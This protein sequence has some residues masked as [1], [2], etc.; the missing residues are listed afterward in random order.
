MADDAGALLVRSGLVTPTALDDARARVENLGGTLGEHL[1][2]AG[3]VSDEVLTDFYRSRLLVPQVNPNTLARLAVRVIA[4]IPSDMA[5]ELRAVPVALDAENNLTVA[6]SDPSDRHAVDEIAFFT[7]SY[8]VRAVATQ[9]QIAWCLAHYYGHVTALGQRL[10]QGGTSE[11]A[12]QPTPAPAAVQAPAPAPR[13]KGL[14]GKVEAMR[15]RGIAPITGPVNLVRPQSG[16]IAAAVPIPDPDPVIEPPVAVVI[17][18]IVEQP[19]RAGGQPDVSSDGV[20]AKPRARSVSGEIRIPGRRAESIKPAVEDPLEDESGPVITVEVSMPNEEE[21]TGPRKVAP[22]RRKVKSDPPELYARAGEVD[23]AGDRERSVDSGPGIIVADDLLEPPPQEDRTGEFEA[24]PRRDAASNGAPTQTIEVSDE[25]SAGVIIHERYDRESEPVLLERRR[26]SDPPTTITQ[27]APS[28][29]DDPDDDDVVV[30][31]AKKPFTR[32]ARPARPTQ[33][34]IGAL[35]AVTRAHR[36]TEAGTPDLD[37]PTGV[38]TPVVAPGPDDPSSDEIAAPPA[39]VRDDTSLHNL[40]EPPKPAP[41]R[42]STSP[43]ARKH[44]PTVDDLDDEDDELGPATSVMSAIELDD[45]IPQRNVDIVPAHLATR[46]HAA[47]PIEHDQVDDGWGPPGTTI[48][49]PLLGAIPGSAGDDVPG[50]IPVSSVDATPLI[51]APPSPPE[52]ARGAPKASP[53]PPPSDA[54][55][56]ATSRLL[57]LIRMLEHASDRDGVVGMM[58]AHL[59]ETHR[60]AGFFVVKAGAT[61]GV[62]E[63]SVFSIVPKPQTLPFATL[64]LDRPS[65]LQDVVGTRLPYR[66]PTHDEASRI[67]LAGVLGVAPVEILLMPV[68]VRE[69]VV[70]VLFAEH[71]LQHTFDDQLALAARA[72]GIALERILMAKRG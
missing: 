12:P 10:L 23:I 28:A 63:L 49:P 15:H 64:R 3:A 31:D 8:V 9:M 45:A 59:S 41:P 37:D 72:A 62:T 54:Q 25:A 14:T 26:P 65:T 56:D 50:R 69:R 52:P 60:R 5:I 57:D 16:Q 11:P 58:V 61:K 1:V 68:T 4:T 71:R 27:R 35:P 18:P 67:F 42:A 53:P 19:V 7:G 55:Q 40:A 39:P 47:A 33:V 46:R 30:L 70:G 32:A 48:P 38:D 24:A 66:G 13:K 36:D 29:A 17:A 20:P 2:F 51:V 34:G 21:A 43:V 6:M 22:K 44:A